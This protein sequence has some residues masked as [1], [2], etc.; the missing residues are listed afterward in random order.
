MAG[1]TA[2][3]N[4]VHRSANNTIAYQRMH[5]RYW[6]ESRLGAPTA[7]QARSRACGTSAVAVPGPAKSV[8]ARLPPYRAARSGSPPQYYD[9]D[10]G[11]QH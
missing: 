11:I 7:Y 5:A 10:A 1:E 9:A 3:R 6:Q 8:S 2:T 4:G